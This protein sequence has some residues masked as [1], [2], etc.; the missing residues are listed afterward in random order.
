MSELI[1]GLEYPF[2]SPKELSCYFPYLITR[3]TNRWQ[4]EQNNNLKE[5]GIQ[6][7]T[8]RILSCLATHSQ[9]TVNELSILSVTEQSTASRTVDQLVNSDLAQRE[10]DDTDQRVRRVS[11]TPKGRKKLRDIAPVVNRSYQQ[12][13]EDID[14]N[15]LAI[16]VSVLQKALKKI[17]VHDL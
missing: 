15:D 14:P 2:N 10:I 5:E 4:I 7:A 6:G 13:I 8:M 1:D 16:C 12:L 17:Q 9:L 11:L 3:L